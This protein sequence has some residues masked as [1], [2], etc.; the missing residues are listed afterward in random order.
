MDS[1]ELARLLA[2]ADQLSPERYPERAVALNQR[3][4]QLDPHNA[5]AYVRLARG[6]QAQQNFS[7]AVAACR[8]ALSRDPQS[9]AA[10]RRLQRITEEWELYQQ[11]QTIQIYEEALRR[12]VVYK[13]QE[14]I[15]G[16][17]ACL[18]RAVELSPSRSR[19]ISCHNALAA[20][21]RSK[22][23][24]ASLDLAAV[25]YEWVLR[26]APG[27]LTARRGLAAVLRER[28]VRQREGERE[29]RRQKQWA[30]RKSYH[31]R[32]QSEQHRKSAS[33]T[34]K[35]PKTL[36]EAL[37]VLNVKSS[38]T[39]SAIKRAYRAQAQVVHPDHGGSHA[40]MVRL[41]AAYTLA[42]A[43]V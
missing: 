26:H 24:T 25:Q 1:P 39:R 2:L 42:L 4:V 38:A 7:A 19:S 17:I 35:Q 23:D 30:Q 16:V 32:T 6:Y 33:A 11:V 21:Y 14:R 36:E 13:D 9:V 12:R 22:R 3:I 15:D 5:A 41:N 40:E 31:Q 28:Q 20:A 29:Q 8:D 43:S 27:N 10:Q 18:W 34:T 37:N